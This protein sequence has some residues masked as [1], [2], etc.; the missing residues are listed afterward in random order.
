MIRPRLLLVVALLSLLSFVTVPLAAQTQQASSLPEPATLDG[1]QQAVVRTWG[2]D[3]EAIL[4][5]TPDYQPDILSDNLTVLG[6]FIFEFDS[7]THAGAAFT[8]YRAGMNDEL[9]TMDVIGDAPI[10]DEALEAPGDQAFSATLVT[11][12]GDY[13]AAVR[14]VLVQDGPRLIVTFAIANDASNAAAANHLA[15]WIAKHG[16]SGGEIA[17]DAT[18]HS[19]GGLWDSFP[20]EDNEMLDTMTPISDE[21]LFPLSGTGTPETGIEQGK[22]PQS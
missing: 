19:R 18:G 22:D 11:I 3:F 21:T 4:A 17:F 20:S 5:A 16:T 15:S 7:A 12:T 2:I 9:R 6:E 10:I 14:Y 13:A 8:I 1:I